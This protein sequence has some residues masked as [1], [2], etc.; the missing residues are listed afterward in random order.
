MNQS[1][2]KN[3]DEYILMFPENVKQLLFE[4]RYVIRQNVPEAVEG[5]AYKMPGY[6]Y[7]GK[8]LVYFAGYQHHV[9]LYATPT[10]Q[11]AFQ[12]ELNAYK[13]GKGSIQFPLDKPLPTDLIISIVKYKA[14]ELEDNLKLKNNQGLL[15]YTGKRD[16]T[17]LLR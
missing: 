12:K 17:Q 9:G 2:F 3:V 4:I 6:K 13:Q 16:E 14:K 7:L 1:E 15:K 10:A 5:I 8:P 11:A